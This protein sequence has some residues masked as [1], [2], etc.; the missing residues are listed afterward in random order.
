MKEELFDKKK[1]SSN[2]LPITITNKGELYLDSTKAREYGEAMSES[3]S[4]AVPFPHIIIDDFLP[5]Q[6]LE[7]I[8]R[9][10]PRKKLADDKFFMNDYSGLNKRQILPESCEERVRNYFLFFNSSPILQFLEGLTKIESLI[11]DPY[12]LGG[13]F[14][15]ITRGG[16][17]GIHADFRIHEKLNLYR[18][19]N[20]IIYLNKE[21]NINYGGKLELWDKEVKSKIKSIAPIFNR[22]V[23]FNTDANSYHGHPEPLDVPNEV[24]RK[25]IAL[26]Y[27]NAS[28]KVYEDTPAHSTMYVARPND[29]KRI[30]RQ[31]M[32]LKLKN[33][34]KDLLPP[35]VLRNFLK[36]FKN[37]KIKDLNK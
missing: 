2:S 33:Y 31:V 6:L 27:Y 19:L 30:K 29:N 16:K 13:G 17:L 10:F 1:T 9:S 23:I 12:F 20:M 28:K 18:R 5:I 11:G 32:M 14:H 35:I 15:E 26:Y 7:E 37:K 22:C 24:T 36:L 34:T 8:I 25:S 3:Y 4:S 21:W